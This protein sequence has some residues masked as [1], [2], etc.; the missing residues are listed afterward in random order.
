MTLF[1]LIVFGVLA[2]SALVGFIRGAARE[3]VTVA[4]FIFAALAAVFLL[5]FTAPLARAAIDPD[6][7]AV[8]VAIAVVFLIVY[9]AVRVFGGS[10]TARIHGSTF[11]SFDRAVGLGFG[12]I[13]GLVFLGVLHLVFHTVTPAE[14]IPVWIKGA[15]TYPLT[16]WTAE[17]LR[18]LT[19]E[20]RA[21]AGDL[22]PAIEKAVRDGAAADP[23]GEGYAS[24]Q[25]S[26]LDALVEQ[27]AK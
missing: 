5:R 8:G 26:D 22:G 1:D 14:R 23:A 6:W 21:T 3:V 17:Q 7:A 13:R 27:R 24:S 4:A 16:G 2:L 19:R 15:A 10:L 18:K 12:L 11:G 9:I 20:G 25:T